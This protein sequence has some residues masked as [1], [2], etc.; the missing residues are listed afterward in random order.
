[1]LKNLVYSL[2]IATILTQPVFYLVPYSAQKWRNLTTIYP[3]INGP[4]ALNL[5]N[6]EQDAAIL[7]C[8]A[9]AAAGIIG[10]PLGGRL[11]DKV[12]QRCGGRGHDDS[13]CHALNASM[14]PRINDIVEV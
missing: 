1:L 2:I 7:V 4:L 12:S 6:D 9:A 14:L 3:W 8:M 10:L 11:A 13:P 5:F